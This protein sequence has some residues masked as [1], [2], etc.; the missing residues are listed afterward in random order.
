MIT[1]G[2]LIWSYWKEHRKV[3]PVLVGLVMA[4]ALYVGRYVYLELRVNQFLMY[5]GIIGIVTVSVWNLWLRKKSRCGACVSSTI[6]ME[7]K[8]E[9]ES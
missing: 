2:G 3:G 7:H 8:S 6:L 9:E 5:G 1:T 4:V